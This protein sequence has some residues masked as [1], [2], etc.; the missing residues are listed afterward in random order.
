MQSK[1]IK[2]SLLFSIAILCVGTTT[3]LSQAGYVQN[4]DSQLQVQHNGPKSMRPIVV[5]GSQAVC[6]ANYD[7]CLRDVVA[8]HLAAT[9][10]RTNYN[11]CLH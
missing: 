2:L 1:L 7:Q 8:R 11:G 6:L 5:A 3:S 10:C 4:N 9:Q